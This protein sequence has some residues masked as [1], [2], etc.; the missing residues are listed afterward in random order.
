[1]EG[2]NFDKLAGSYFMAKWS[3][4]DWLILVSLSQIIAVGSSAVGRTWW[5]QRKVRGISLPPIPVSISKET[6]T[7]AKESCIFLISIPSLRKAD[8]GVTEPLNTLAQLER[9]QNFWE[10]TEFLL[11]WTKG[12]CWLFQVTCEV[13][14]FYRRKLSYCTERV[15]V[16]KAALSG[17]L[18]MG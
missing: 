13:R 6:W 7:Q 14:T 11:L 17:V 15:T 2:L 1:M 12:Q 8:P 16:G 5:P 3:K 10:E 4:W 9:S 18:E